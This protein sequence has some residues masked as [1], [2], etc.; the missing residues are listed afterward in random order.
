MWRRAEN[1]SSN[2]LMCEVWVC[3]CWCCCDGEVLAGALD[4]AFSQATFSCIIN[5]GPQSVTF[6]IGCDFQE[7][8]GSR[9]L[10]K[11]KLPLSNCDRAVSRLPQLSCSI[12]GFHGGRLR[13]QSCMALSS[14]FQLVGRNRHRAGLER[15][16]CGVVVL[17]RSWCFVIRSSFL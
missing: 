16:L 13:D 4:G 17:V 6:A 11:S 2:M 15:S 3:W 1:V 10:Q 7:P 14:A 9:T 12:L 5:H 8:W